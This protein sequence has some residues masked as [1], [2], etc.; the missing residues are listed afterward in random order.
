MIN[1]EGRRVEGAV[2]NRGVTKLPTVKIFRD[3]PCKNAREGAD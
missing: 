2:N 1:A 3:E